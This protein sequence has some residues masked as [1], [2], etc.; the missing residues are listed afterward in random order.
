MLHLIYSPYITNQDICIAA[1]CHKTHS[2]YGLNGQG[3]GA[4][5][6]RDWAC[7]AHVSIAGVASVFWRA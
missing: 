1:A 5:W 3:V 4:L 7:D 2:V 6:I